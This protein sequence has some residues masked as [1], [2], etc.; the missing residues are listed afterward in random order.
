MMQQMMKRLL[1]KMDANQ[2]EMKA[3]RKADREELKRMMN[4][5]QEITA[6]QEHMQEMFRT[7]KEK[8]DAWIA[9]RKNDRKE[10]TACQYAMETRLKNMEPNSAEKKAVVGRQEISNGEVAIHSLSA[11]RSETAAS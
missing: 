4:A 9:N 7:N 1:T 8:M 3:D 6:G 10:T 11:C 5:T 2:A